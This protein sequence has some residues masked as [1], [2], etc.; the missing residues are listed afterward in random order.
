[1]CSMRLCKTSMRST[2]QSQRRSSDAFDRMADSD[3]SEAAVGVS[4]VGI[5]KPHRHEFSP[6][7]PFSLIH[8]PTQEATALQLWRKAQW[9][10]SDPSARAYGRRAEAM[11]PGLR[12]LNWLLR[13][14][15]QGGHASADSAED[16]KGTMAARPPQ[17]SATEDGS[18]RGAPLL[19][20]DPRLSGF[21]MS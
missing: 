13:R 20:R 10:S 11:A 7:P 9:V 2:E 14:S 17:W 6:L 21:S 16:T 8:P 5:Q 3:I 19:T 12:S 4:E 1:M 18:S 15:R